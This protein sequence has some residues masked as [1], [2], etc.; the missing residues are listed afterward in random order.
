[1]HRPALLVT[2][3]CLVALVLYAGSCR[4]DEL[5]GYAGGLLSDEGGDGNS[6][7]SYALEYRRPVYG[8]FAGSFTW[9][10]EGHITNH[11]RD[12]QS[13]Q[14]WWRSQP[15]ESVRGLSFDLGIGPYRYYDTTRPSP[16]ERYAN[17][18]GWGW[19]ASAEA[20][21]RF[22]SRWYGSLRL[23]QVDAH[24]S[25]DST[26]VM[27]GVGYIF[28]VRNSATPL[29]TSLSGPSSGVEVDALAGE[30]IL[31]SFKSQTN[32]TGGIGARLQ[33]T[34]WL[35]GSATYLNAGESDGGWRSAA[36]LQLWAE[37]ALTQ[38]VTVGASVGG[39]FPFDIGDSAHTGK[40]RTSAMIGVEAAYYYDKH[41]VGRFI[42]DRVGTG[43]NH[44]SDIYLFNVGYRF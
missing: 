35:S 24:G 3:A 34:N 28:D 29:D 37:Q 18:H 4:A 21:Y 36:A 22:D 13:I 17:Q 11:H 19:L 40:D 44:D 10:N 14:A 1:M 38:H 42:W 41:W 9:L 6:T 32:A 2:S 8:D 23:N 16:D 43:D 31:N 33:M 25:F 5:T 20:D 26:S 15:D 39:F 7:Y 27:V 30:T 12:G